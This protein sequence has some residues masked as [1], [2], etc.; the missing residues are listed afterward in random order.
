MHDTRTPDRGTVNLAADSVNALYKMPHNNFLGFETD[1]ALTNNLTYA[2][3]F[4][5]SLSDL[6][7][8]RVAYFGSTLDTDNTGASTSTLKNVSKTGLYNL[9]SR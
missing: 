1:R 2:L 8:V 4:D 3:R 6:F 9:R 7:S 5:R